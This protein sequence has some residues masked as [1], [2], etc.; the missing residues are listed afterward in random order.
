MYL[1]SNFKLIL[2]LAKLR[3]EKAFIRSFARLETIQRII[4]LLRSHLNQ[5]HKNQLKFNFTLECH[6]AKKPSYSWL[7]CLIPN[8]DKTSL[9]VSIFLFILIGFSWFAYAEW[10][11]VLVVGSNPTYSNRGSAVRTVI[12]PPMESVLC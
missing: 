12:H 9:R 1:L 2:P 6:F 8:S 4:T 11:T 10:R 7:N 5:L 3:F